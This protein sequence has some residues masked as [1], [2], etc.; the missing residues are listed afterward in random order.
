MNIRSGFT[1]VEIMIVVV[2]IAL[3]AAMMIPAL[4]KVRDSSLLKQAESGQTKD[5]SES[6]WNRY[7]ELIQ[8]R[9][10]SKGKAEKAVRENSAHESPV[11]P[12]S[13]GSLQRLT[14]GGKS[15]ILVPKME[16]KETEIAGRVFWLVPEAP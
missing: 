10:L 14:I 4:S 13:S 9:S 1:L 8:E 7:R 5:W 6:K 2:I 11:Q 16:A 12:V 15:Y 3:L